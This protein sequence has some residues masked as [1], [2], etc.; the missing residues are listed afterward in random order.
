MDGE[1]GLVMWGVMWVMWGG[2]WGV[3]GY[4]CHKHFK[5]AKSATGVQFFLMNASVIC[6]TRPPA[7]IDKAGDE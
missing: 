1:E 6:T 5:Y 3:C 7:S 4:F 2:R